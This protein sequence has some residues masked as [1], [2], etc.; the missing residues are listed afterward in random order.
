MYYVNKVFYQIC[1]Y[2]QLFVRSKNKAINLFFF[3]R[4]GT[5]LVWRKLVWR[6]LP[7]NMRF[8]SEF[9]VCGLIIVRNIPELR[10]MAAG[11]KFINLWLVSFW[12]WPEFPDFLGLRGETSNR[13]VNALNRLS[14]WGRCAGRA[15]TTGGIQRPVNKYTLANIQYFSCILASIKRI[16]TRN[17]GSRDICRFGTDQ[18][19]NSVHFQVLKEI[20][21][22]SYFFKL[23]K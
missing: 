8:Y 12:L 1:W 11:R 23:I 20:Y 13:E 14:G 15:Q 4:I 21:L 16:I 3:Y 6:N 10:W 22:L 2:T 9:I 7:G 5:F 17:L 18:I 19:F